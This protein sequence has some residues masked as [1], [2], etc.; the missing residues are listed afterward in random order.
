MKEEHSPELS[1]EQKAIIA[2]EK[3]I[4]EV[5]KY[6]LPPAQDSKPKSKWSLIFETVG[7]AALITV[8]V[9][10]IFGGLITALVQFNQKE[11]E[12]Q[13]TWL[14]ARGDMA[15][16]AS[17]EYRDKELETVS[18]AYDLLGRCIAVSDDLIYLTNPVF[19]PNKYEDSRSIEE[20]RVTMIK[21][22]NSCTREW[23]EQHEKMR[24]LISYYHNGDPKLS[25]AWKKVQESATNYMD[26]GHGWYLAH[27]RNPID[28]EGACKDEREKYSTMVNE[29]NVSF[30]AA[31]QYMWEGWESPEMLREAL[32]KR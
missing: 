32:R 20:Q 4:A 11:R 5:L 9:G 30:D 28:T 27:I 1:D 14:K 2:H 6:R 21:N 23:R 25:E 17:K 3:F 22:Y 7:G 8:L 10:G 15:L 26:C 29:L 13:Q 18:Q 31:R 24:L 19:D 16:A 12:F